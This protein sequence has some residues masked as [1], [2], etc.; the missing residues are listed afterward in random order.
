MEV[1]FLMSEVPLC[2]HSSTLERKRSCAHLVGENKQTEAEQRVGGSGRIRAG[3]APW[4]LP[5]H[6][7][8]FSRVVRRLKAHKLFITHHQARV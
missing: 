8:L 1:L 7:Y 2:I 5:R 6:M 4:D 3:M